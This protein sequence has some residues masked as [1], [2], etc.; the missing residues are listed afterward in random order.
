MGLLGELLQ[1]A[2]NTAKYTVKSEVNSEIRNG[3]RSLKQKAKQTITEQLHKG[4][5]S[6]T[7][8]EPTLQAHRQTIE[9]HLEAAGIGKKAEE[10]EQWAQQF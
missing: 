2:V 9:E 3:I 7:D 4:E 8:I 1:S 6:S 10:M 5:K